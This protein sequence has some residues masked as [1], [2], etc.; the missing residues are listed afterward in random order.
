VINLALRLPV[1][2][3][4]GDIIINSP[5]CD[6]SKRKSRFAVAKGIYH[7]VILAFVDTV[8]KK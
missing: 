4:V 5:F 6:R 1:F 3:P 2:P 8:S 7:E